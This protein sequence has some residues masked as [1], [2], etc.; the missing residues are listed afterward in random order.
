MG[1]EAFEILDLDVS[2]Y[3]EDDKYEHIR[4]IA[5]HYK[6]VKLANENASVNIPEEFVAAIHWSNYDM[7]SPIDPQIEVPASTTALNAF[8]QFLEHG[9]LDHLTTENVEE[10][11]RIAVWFHYYDMTMHIFKWMFDNLSL[12]N[13][14]RFYNLSKDFK[15]S[16]YFKH[17]QTYVLKNFKALN[18]ITNGFPTVSIATLNA[19]L[20]NDN[21]GIKDEDLFD[22]ILNWSK[23]KLVLMSHVRFC[24]LTETFIKEK[25]IP[26]EQLKDFPRNVCTIVSKLRRYSLRKRK[27]NSHKNRNPSEFVL[28]IGG[29]CSQH[30]P[31]NDEGPAYCMEVFDNREVKWKSSNMP[32]KRAYHGAEVINDTLYIFGGFLRRSI[33]GQTDGYYARETFSYNPKGNVWRGRADMKVSRCYVSSASLYGL[34][35]AIGGFNGRYRLRSAE[36]FNP[37]L[38]Y[39]APLPPMTMTR[40]DG[41]AVGFQ[42]KVYAIG[43]F[44]GEQIHSSIEIYNPMTN[45]WTFGPS[46]ITAR[47]GVKAIVYHGKIYVIGGYDGGRRLKSVEVF[48]GRTWTEL[49]GKMNLRRSN[50]AVTVVD[51]QIM[52]M[53]GF[54]GEKVTEEVEVYDDIHQVWTKTKPMTFDRSALSAVTMN[55]F[56]LSMNDFRRFS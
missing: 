40:S 46:M 45:E 11:I 16:A 3:F 12:D 23:D 42:G 34:I 51:D 22:I 53:G 24:K 38:N 20:G 33:M 14:I 29:W 37:E 55:H 6:N 50:F 27:C 7:E 32:I 30:T 1:S 41:C 47:S 52:V 17:F 35:Y 4:P 54:Q 28:A 13:S 18:E 49:P 10:I 48:D 43:G 9:K 31:R 36:V 56:M 21:L 25:V 8:A 15:V 2:C 26:C 39:W 44:D 5:K 19:W